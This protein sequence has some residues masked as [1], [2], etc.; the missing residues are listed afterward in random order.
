[1][2]LAI[3]GK[4]SFSVAIG[5]ILFALFLI[6]VSFYVFSRIFLD[7][8]HKKGTFLAILMVIIN[9]LSWYVIFFPFFNS[10]S[11]VLIDDID[12]SLS[13]L[14]TIF[15]I[16]IYLI[17][18]ALRSEE[19]K[20]KIIS[21]EFIH[22]RMDYLYHYRFFSSLLILFILMLIFLSPLLNTDTMFKASTSVYW[23]T[24]EV[25]FFTINLYYLDLIFFGLLF[26][27]IIFMEVQK[28]MMGA[29]LEKIIPSRI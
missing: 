17:F 16:L 13:V 22:E 24:E 27:P 11:Q 10:Y 23:N 14:S 26:I 28:R 7:Y 25:S 19:L 3:P 1:M 29:G 8:S 2:L 6:F 12:I 9:F 21:G 4:L 18:H 5:S 15:L 20:R